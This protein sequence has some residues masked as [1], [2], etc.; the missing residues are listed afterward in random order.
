MTRTLAKKQ[1]EVKPGTLF[2]G[3]DLGD[4]E[5]VAVVQSER[6]EWLAKFSFPHTRGGYDYLYRRMNH[7]MKGAD[8]T[9]VIVGMEP[10]NYY[11]KLLVADLEAHGIEYHLV[12][13]YT[14]KKH[15]EGD[16]LDRSKDDTRDAYTIGGLSRNGKYTR[17]RLQRGGYAELRTCATLYHQLRGDL[18]RQKTLLRTKVGQ[19]YPELTQEFKDLTGLTARAMLRRHACAAVIRGMAVE[20]FIAAVRADF[21]GQ[22]LMVSKLRRAHARAAISVGL[23]D[24]VQRL[25]LSI[26]VHLQTLEMLESQLE[27]AEKAL[28]DTFLTLP[29]AP[30]LLSVPELGIV[31]A[32]LILAEI[33][34]PRHFTRVGQ[35]IKLAGTQPT[36]NSSGKKSKSLTPMSGKGRPGLRTLAYFACLRLIQL[37]PGFA[38]RYHH[39]QTRSKNPLNKMQA[40]GVL[41]N[42]LLRILWALMKKQTFY[43]PAMI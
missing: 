15:R 2:V 4:K 20:D 30:Y 23:K 19:A 25:Q 37:D 1:T 14:V 11:W 5:N 22:R 24:G 21:D 38:R 34:D 9:Q 27:E 42:K 29:E 32:A 43:N 28:I 18:G 8:A 17:T 26:S 41:M 36:P 31:S 3:T 7:L 40:I 39:L 10:T 12:N 16:Q 13:A 33:G 6:G 35:L